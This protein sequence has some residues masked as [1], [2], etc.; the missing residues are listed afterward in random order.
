M[1]SNLWRIAEYWTSIFAKTTQTQIVSDFCVSNYWKVS[2][3]AA[4]N[5][6]QK[7]RQC[8]S[9]K[10]L[11]L[12]DSLTGALPLDPAG[13][14][15]PRLPLQGSYSCIGKGLQLSGAGRHCF[16]SSC[17]ISRSSILLLGFP[18]GRF[19]SIFPFSQSSEDSHVLRHARSSLLGV[20]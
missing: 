20:A 19:P 15:A 4:S 3:F 18:L 8:F 11:C 5:K 1:Y 6:H 2:K 14:S 12:P 13:G 17:S 7:S 10:G 9:F 16:L